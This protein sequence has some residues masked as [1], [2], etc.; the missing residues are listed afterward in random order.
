[1]PYG[2]FQVRQPDRWTIK[3]NRAERRKVAR[4]SR[5]R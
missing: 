1:M 5:K 2:W 3:P 4:K